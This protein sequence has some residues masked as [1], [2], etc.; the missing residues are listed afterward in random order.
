MWAPITPHCL[1]IRITSGFGGGDYAGRPTTPSLRN[2]SRRSKRSFHG[3]CCNGK[4][5]KQG[6][7][8]RLLE[9]YAAR[10]PSFNDD[11]QGT[12]AVTVAGIL[13]G[14]RLSREVLAQQRFLMVGAGAAG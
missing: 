10:L 3:R 14:L 7:A 13:S 5:S 12:A 2:S 11:I 6:N 9:R 4:I 8:F 1:K